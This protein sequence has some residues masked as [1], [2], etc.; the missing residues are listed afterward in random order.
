MKYDPFFERSLE[1]LTEEINL[2]LSPKGYL[3]AGLPKFKALFGRDSLITGWELIDWKV[4]IALSSVHELAKLQGRT[5]DNS[6]GEYPGKIPHEYY[7]SDSDYWTRR[8]EISWLPRGP[9]Y[10][11]VDSTPLFVILVSILNARVPGSL[12][13]G[14]RR[15]AEK[16]LEFIVQSSSS[17]KLLVYEKDDTA[18]GL[19][20]QS[21][22][23][24]IGDV[25]DA[26]KYPVATVGAQGYLYASLLAGANLLSKGDDDT[27][28]LRNSIRELEKRIP[29]QLEINFWTEDEAFYALAVDGLGRPETAVTSDPGH[30][31]FSGILSREREREVVDRLFES[32]MLT[33]Y[34]IRTLSTHDKRFDPRAYQRGA[35]WPQDN[36]IIFYGLRM[37]GYGRESSEIRERLLEAY[38]K[39]GRM[40]EYFGVDKE[41]VLISEN[42][43]MISPC[44]PQAWSTGA[45]IDF[46]LDRA[47]SGYRPE[48]SEV[49]RNDFKT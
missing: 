31:I 45:I 18:H 4:D 22:R 27:G 9:N 35:I 15:A 36:W 6:T 3:Y 42:K 20:S 26:L 48:I 12:S 28:N 39:M 30:L 10:F 7:E 43:M 5:M 46:L 19:R 13:D 17:R 38:D 33:D 44:Y 25:L 40:P 16:A 1:R 21:W 29:Q 8:K 24:G 32:D 37:R 2:L 34:G 23:D 41:G 49:I 11:S 47:A 14:I